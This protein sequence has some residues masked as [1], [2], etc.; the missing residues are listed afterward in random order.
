MNIL[1]TGAN[2]YIGKSLYN[3]FKH[4]YNVTAITRQDYDLTNY[5]YLKKLFRTDY[6]VV[7]HCAV[8]GGNR[9]KQDS[10]DVMDNNLR[11]YYNLLDYKHSYDKFIHFGSGAEITAANTPYGLS[12][13]VISNSISEIDKFYDIRIFGVFDENE[14]DTRFIKSNI[15]RYLNKQS[16]EIHNDKLMDFFYM[17]DLITLVNY[18]ITNDVPYKSSVNCTYLNSLKL[19]DIANI[20][21]KLDSYQVDININ[22]TKNIQ[23]YIGGFNDIV[24]PYIGLE[25][26]IQETY[27]KLKEHYATN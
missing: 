14:L 2:G 21:N 1:I 3:A 19:S 9:L 10:W 12:K 8:T 4:K 26:G 17:K 15:I 20:I 16:M 22:E 23:S 18:F 6:D 25:Q 7:L 24:L 11:M 27:I 5:Q 13:K